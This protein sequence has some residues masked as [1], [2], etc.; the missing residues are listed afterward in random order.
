MVTQGMWERDS[1]LLQLPHFTK[2]LAKR[3]QENN[4]ETVFDLVE[5]EDEERLEL[6]SMSDTELL[7]IAKFC[8]RFPNSDLTYE[9][10]GSEDVTPG[11]E[12]TLER[13]MEGR[14]EVGAVDAPRYPKTKEE[15]WWLVVGDTKTN[16]L[17]AIKRVSLQKKAKVKLDFQVPSEAG[18]KPYTLLHALLD[19]RESGKT[20]ITW[21]NDSCVSG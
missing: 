9:F 2:E 5:M 12:V 4:I 17:V 3:C 10:V 8:N 13:D 18:E 14:T 6:L 1:V 16:Q 11:K 20:V 7:D 19:S 21:K 15:G